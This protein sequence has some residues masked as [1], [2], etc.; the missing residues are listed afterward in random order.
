M[1]ADSIRLII[2]GLANRFPSTNLWP[3]QGN[4]PI[5]AYPR[6]QIVPDDE[7]GIY[8]CIARCVRRA[9]L[10]GADPITGRDYEHRKLWIRDRLEQL[11]AIFAI[12]ICGYAVMSNH[13]HLVLRVRSDLARD[14][15]DDELARRW[16]RLY[17]PRDPASGEPIEP[18]ECDLNRI[19]SDPARVAV[20]R[21]RLASLSC[22]ASVEMGQ[23]VCSNKLQS[24]VEVL[25]CP[26]KSGIASQL[27]R[28]SPFFGSISS[29]APPSRT[30]VT[31]TGSFHPRSVLPDNEESQSAAPR[32]KPSLAAELVTGNHLGVAAV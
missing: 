15:S 16:L 18:S 1:A 17:P 7:V 21:Q 6:S 20:I 28:K 5:P 10:C 19:L 22:F 13:L 9:F 8:H 3:A 26:R 14:C 29:N 31:S 12:E 4:F 11:A 25:P 32:T 30:C 23:T 2:S 24:R 27:R